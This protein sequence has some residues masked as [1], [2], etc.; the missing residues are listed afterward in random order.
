MLF[1]YHIGLD[2]EL[3]R[4]ISCKIAWEYEKECEYRKTLACDDIFDNDF[5]YHFGT[6]VDL[7]GRMFKNAWKYEKKKCICRKVL[8]YDA[9]VDNVFLGNFW[10]E[11]ELVRW[12][13]CKKC[14]GIRK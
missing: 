12:M 7:M 13:L 4:W 3:A 8:S 14:L 1:V 10:L 9:V 11:A 5:F 6:D 2:V